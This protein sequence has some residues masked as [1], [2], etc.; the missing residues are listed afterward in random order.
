MGSLRWHRVGQTYEEIAEAFWTY[1]GVSGSFPRNIRDACIWALPVALVT[2]PGLGTAK[3]AA[4][5]LAKG[6]G[7][8]L[9]KIYGDVGLYGCVLGSRGVGFIFVEENLD[10]DEFSLTLAHEVAHF[11]MDYLMPREEALAKLGEAIRPV[12][13]GERPPATAERVDALLSGVPLGVYLNATPAE[14]LVQFEHRADMLAFELLA[15]AGDVLRQVSRY[16]ASLCGDGHP[17]TPG[18]TGGML[19][20]DRSPG[21]GPAGSGADRSFD[22]V[23][24][25]V[26]RY[27]LPPAAALWYA[28]YLEVTLPPGR[29]G[30]SFAEWLAGTDKRV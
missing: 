25:L 21:Q 19:G 26:M 29:L 28:R 17:G 3:A 15:P 5:P 4:H 23:E 11:I 16:A 7:S 12:L 8:G 22:V 2:V 1:A 27:G 14:H 24:L 30:G 9:L 6:L 13:D 18:Q 20:F 10:R